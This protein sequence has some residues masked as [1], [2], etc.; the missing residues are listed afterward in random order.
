M[1]KGDQVKGSHLFLNPRVLTLP[2]P[3]GLS[4]VGKPPFLLERT[5]SL[6]GV[7]I[8]D[9]TSMGVSEP[10]R[11]FTSRAEYRLSL[12]AENADARLTP[13]AYAAGVVSDLRHAHFTERQALLA[14]AMGRLE[15]FRMPAAA[16]ADRGFKFAGVRVWFHL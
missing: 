1:E 12:R 15:A 10:Y 14:G 6:I 8:D 11:M 9:L 13:R 5:D 3:A 16:W 2:I 4:A 7:M